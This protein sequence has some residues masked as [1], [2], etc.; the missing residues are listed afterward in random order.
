MS[1]QVILITGTPCVG[2]TTVA[3][4][5][6]TGLDALYINLTDLANKHNLTSGEDKEQ[7]R[8]F[9]N[10]TRGEPRPRNVRC[11]PRRSPTRA[12][13]RK[14]M[15]A[16]CHWQDSEKNLERN[17]CHNGQTQKVLYRLRRLAPRRCN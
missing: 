9:E 4:Q 13:K 17:H 2:K 3:K 7:K 6:T 15:R 12:Q 11:L 14:S 1:K 8:F 5:L 16:G 10:Q